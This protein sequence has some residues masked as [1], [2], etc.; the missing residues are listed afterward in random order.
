V[1]EPKLKSQEP[2]SQE[3]KSELDTEMKKKKLFES[4]K[5]L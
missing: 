4:M 2:K 5:K 3:P 1:A